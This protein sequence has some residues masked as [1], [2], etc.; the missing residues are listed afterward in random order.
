MGKQQKTAAARR[1]TAN[2]DEF[3]AFTDRQLVKA[4]EKTVNVFDLTGRNAMLAIFRL[5]GITPE[6]VEETLKTGEYNYGPG[7]MMFDGLGTMSA[8]II[9]L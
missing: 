5:Y 7:N 6:L 8:R 9:T 1:K 4:Y 3:A 2:L